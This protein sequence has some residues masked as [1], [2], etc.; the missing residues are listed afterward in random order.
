MASFSCVLICEE[1][2]GLRCLQML[3]KAGFRVCAVFTNTRHVTTWCEQTAIPVHPRGSPIE[4]LVEGKSFH[5]LFSINNPRILS[6]AVLELPC[7]LTINFHDSPLP[8]YAGV[9]ATCWAILQGQTV[10]GVT[11]HSVDSGIDTG[12]LLQTEQ[13]LIDPHESVLSLNIK[14]QDACL[15]A[16]RRLLAD[17]QADVLKPRKQNSETRSYFGLYDMPPNLGVLNFEDDAKKSYDLVRA[18]DFG[19]LDNQFGSAKICSPNG[20]FYLVTRAE[21]RQSHQKTE[22]SSNNCPGSILDLVGNILIVNTKSRT[23][24]LTLSEL[25]GTRLVVHS[26]PDLVRGKQLKSLTISEPGV[27][28]EIRKKEAF[29][30]KKLYSYDPT[31][32]PVQ[33]LI[34]KPRT[35]RDLEVLMNKIVTI[36]IPTP[37]V[38][39][40]VFGRVWKDGDYITAALVL[41]LGRV[42]CSK[43]VHLGLAAD[44][45]EIPEEIRSLYS[46]IVPGTFSVDFCESLSENMIKC[47]ESLK[48][49]RDGRTFSIDMRHRYPELRGIGQSPEHNVLLDF[50]EGSGDDRV[51]QDR[52]DR[53]QKSANLFLKIQSEKITVS[54]QDTSGQPG[55]EIVELMKRFPA[56]LQAISEHSE[57]SSLLDIPLLTDEELREHYPPLP[58]KIWETEEDVDLL[59]LIWS[60]SKS[61]PDHLALISTRNKLTYK[62]LQVEVGH[63]SDQISGVIQDVLTSLA[64]KPCIALHLP[65]SPAFVASVLA[66]VSLDCVFL[67]IP[68]DLPASRRSF[69]LR[70]AN[71]RLM[72]T[73]PPVAEDTSSLP[74]FKTL[75]RTSTVFGD[76]H[77]LLF[78]ADDDKPEQDNGHPTDK[79]QNDVSKV[80]DK[81]CCYII[82][83]SGSTGEPKG[84]QC[85]KSGI[86]NL[87]RGQIE[88][89]NLGPHDTQAQFASIGFDATVSEIFTT[90]LSGATMAVLKD[91]E[92]LG[93]ELSSTITKLGVTIVTFPPSLLNIYK[94]EDFPTLEKVVTAGE[95]CVVSIAERWTCNSKKRFFNAYGPAENTVCATMFEFLSERRADLLSEE[96]PIGKAIPG[97]RVYLLDDFR[98]PVPSGMVGEIYIGGKSLSRG[99]IGHAYGKNSERF[100]PNCLEDQSQSIEKGTEP[101]PSGGQG[102]AT[103]ECQNQ[104][105]KMQ[106]LCQDNNLVHGNQGQTPQDDQHPC[107]LGMLYRTGDHAVRTDNGNL[108]FLGRVDNQVKLRGQMVNLAEVEMIIKQITAVKMV[109]VVK[110]PGSETSDPYI[111]AFVAPSTVNPSEIREHL[112]RTLPKFAVPS[113]IRAIETEEFPSNLSGKVDRKK[114]EVEDSVLTLDSGKLKARS[115]LTQTQLS[116]AKIWCKVLGL[117][118][119]RAYDMNGLTS[120]YDTGGNSLHLVLLQRALELELQ[121][122][123]SFTELGGAATIEELDALVQMKSQSH[124]GPKQVDFNSGPR[125][126]QILRYQLLQDAKLG[127]DRS[128]QKVLLSGATGFL[129]AFLL[130]EIMLQTSAHVWCMVRASTIVKAFERVVVNMRQYNLWQDAFACRICVVLSDISKPKLG[131][132]ETV[133]KT[134][135]NEIDVVFMNGAKMNFNTDYW[136]HKVANVDGTKE[137]IAFAMFSKKKFIFSTSSLSVFLFPS[138]ERVEKHKGNRVVFKENDE[139]HDPVL[140]SGGYGQSKWVS[141]KLVS[142]ALDKGL[143]GA[144]FRPARVSGDSKTG[145][146]PTGD[147]FASL[148]IGVEQLGVAPNLD[149]PFDL[150]PVDYCA[151]AMVEIMTQICGDSEKQMPR[152][153]HLFNHATI[154]FRQLFAESESILELPL[155]EWREELTKASEDNPLLPMA[156]FFHSDFWDRAAQCW[157]VFDTSN[158]NRYV[159]KACHSLLQPTEQLL[160]LYWNFFHSQSSDT[161]ASPRRTCR[162]TGLRGLKASS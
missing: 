14:C 162:A 129:G 92:R 145:V 50:S 139:L 148:L 133:Y 60:F 34:W 138:S 83:T 118:L 64:Q 142:Q 110:R 42:C 8:A 123:L 103:S 2:T 3:K 57:L 13:V 9:N 62:Q 35:S 106:I 11:W 94:P 99:Y 117:D 146:G 10:H 49:Y 4:K 107:P 7:R 45:S 114:L 156:P 63:L 29:W 33:K 23:L 85:T 98:K 84:I 76:L 24:H 59:Q 47:S 46:P 31:K 95:A 73:C 28:K 72:L 41:F 79:S 55:V 112:L 30:R 71:C 25:D 26:S 113:V 91:T 137:F 27:A 111:A 89:W 122:R 18:L 38:P 136:D 54:Y 44:M 104:E 119:T 19:S 97:V 80:L 105:H 155:D 68:L 51:D 120:F 144:I 20:R 22:A 16:F 12:E 160:K 153:Y 56:F 132:D 5:Y 21:T 88:F 96:L 40:R 1:N 154:S 102:D 52:L 161:T 149:F 78:L 87:A 115:S 143:G 130:H 61:Q 101:M 36:D 159:S 70:D 134:L 116:L 65:N 6:D 158:T 43:D 121:V 152:V 108:I 17:I 69:V 75:L 128:P 37:Q 100:R 67:P 124:V 141:E 109:A 82:Y 66:S 157:P 131:I 48:R 93:R 140:L 86:L 77:L 127:A 125:R 53:L 150:T 151:K 32:L 81:D 135:A 74:A 90:F 147:L 58:E 39:E 15:V 126:D